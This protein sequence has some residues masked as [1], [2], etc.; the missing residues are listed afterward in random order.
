M[1]DDRRIALTLPEG[2]SRPWA[3][4]VAGGY[5]LHPPRLRDPET[6]ATLAGTSM[7]THWRVR[8]ANPGRRSTA[9]A[10]RLVEERLACIVRQM[11]HWEAESDLSR[12]GRAPA[13][14]WQALP[15]PFFHVLQ[16]ALHWARE[17]DGARDPA[18]AP[19][20][21]LWGFGPR[22]RLPA[23]GQPWQPP[24]AAECD[25]WLRTRPALARLR[26][27]PATRQAWQPG[28]LALDL[29][30]IAKGFAVDWVLC[31]LRGA[32]WTDMLVEIGG[33]VR[34]S[35]QRPDG[36][37]WRVAIATSDEAAPA[38]L[39]L[40][41]CAVATSGDQWQAHEHA[42]QRHGHTMDPRQG[43]PAASGVAAVTVLHSSC[44][45]ADALA[46]ILL[47]LDADAA[48]SF[49]EGRGIAARFQLRTERGL[50]IRQSS[51]FPDPA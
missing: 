12:F 29:S 22:A 6:L 8:L 27:R 33:E 9:E 5:V 21:A 38:L 20:V 14:T 7:G 15:Q 49:A 2:L 50:E 25:A 13:A 11:S 47:V 3:A 51:R 18:V 43:R 28:G 16:A 24:P 17:S 34:A 10:R 23:P 40:R 4:P 44:M 36:R 46:T 30:A 19:L 31:G 48:L 26:L 42:G 37:P 35:G 45:H 32:G 41:D 1:P 39:T